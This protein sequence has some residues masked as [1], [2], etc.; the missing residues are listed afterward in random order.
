MNS[1][2]K[3]AKIMAVL[4]A[5]VLLLAG[6]VF[7]F[8]RPLYYRIYPF[9]RIT[10]T[11]RIAIDGENYD[12]KAGDVTGMLDSSEIKVGFRN[13]A[14]GAELSVRG[15]E[16]G[17]YRLM[18]HVDG[19]SSPLEAVVYQTNRWNVSKFELEI[20]IDRAAETITFTSSAK[21]V[22]AGSGWIPENHTTTEDFSNGKYV[23]FIVSV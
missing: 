15:G 22:N 9:D 7:L 5:A 23:F 13:G 2:R 18:I 10:G 12:L 14:D 19:M 6:T 20:S 8:F 1:A 4:L 17:P 3:A 16:Y 11:V 21:V